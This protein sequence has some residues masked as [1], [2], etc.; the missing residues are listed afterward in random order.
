MGFNGAESTYHDLL[1]QFADGS[2][3]AAEFETRFL[4]LRREKEFFP[5]RRRAKLVDRLM[6]DVDAFCGD[7]QLRDPGDLDEDQL[8]ASVRGILSEW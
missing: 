7:P 2:I 3:D 5:L 4:A 6:V 1:Q 8:K